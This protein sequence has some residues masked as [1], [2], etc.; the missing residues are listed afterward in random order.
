VSCPRCGVG[1]IY[2]GVTVD[3]PNMSVADERLYAPSFGIPF[4]C[5]ECGAIKFPLTPLRDLVYIWDDPVKDKIGSF[6]I[7]DK[8]A[9]HVQSY[10]GKILAI[11]P[12]YS[13]G[14]R[15]FPTELHVG[16]YVAFNRSVPHRVSLEGNDGKI[17]PVRMVGEQDIVALVDEADGGN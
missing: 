3:T 17:Y 12:G 6:Y 2:P 4:Y 14:G 7:P 1:V 9:K 11:G 15:F 13:K 10:F 16:D 8:K 5:P